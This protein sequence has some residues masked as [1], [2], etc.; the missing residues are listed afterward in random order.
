MMSARPSPSRRRSLPQ[1]LAV[2]TLLLLA[3]FAAGSAFADNRVRILF[4][5]VNDTYR[6]L[7]KNPNPPKDGC[8]PA[9]DDSDDNGCVT[10]AEADDDGQQDDPPA[11]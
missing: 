11:P 10:E 1:V 6:P 5:D 3:I 9:V 8:R 4:D 2:A 7:T